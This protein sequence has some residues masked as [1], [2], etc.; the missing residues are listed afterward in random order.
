[1]DQKLLG[2]P[3]HQVGF[4]RR[5]AWTALKNQDLSKDEFFELL[6]IG[7]NDP[8]YEVRTVSW[9]AL[10]QKLEKEGWDLTGELK[11]DLKEE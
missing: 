7:L 2:E 1:M 9:Q 11:S 6:Q 8:Y 5:N 4:I 3:F 10:A